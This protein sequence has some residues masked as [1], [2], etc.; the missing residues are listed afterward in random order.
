MNIRPQYTGK[1]VAEVQTAYTEFELYMEKVEAKLERQRQIRR[2]E[3]ERLTTRL[4]PRKF[5][6][7]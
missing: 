5:S 1:A 4:R 6:W 3:Q 2:R 7:E